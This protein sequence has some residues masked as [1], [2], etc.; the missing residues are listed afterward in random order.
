MAL[1]EGGARCLEMTKRQVLKVWN[2]LVANM[3]DFRS[4]LAVIPASP[5]DSEGR[6]GTQASNPDG[7]VPVTCG[8]GPG[9]GYAAP[10]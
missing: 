2:F 5:R 1:G 10:G 7:A 6:A 9:F 3:R 8:L 4:S